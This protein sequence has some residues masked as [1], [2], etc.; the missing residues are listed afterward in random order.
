M[1]KTFETI[2]E[3][4]S[5]V[6]SLMVADYVDDIDLLTVALAISSM[7]DIAF[8]LNQ[9]KRS[10][11]RYIAAHKALDIGWNVALRDSLAK[12]GYFENGLRGLLELSEEN[13]NLGSR[14]MPT[15]SEAISIYKEIGLSKSFKRELEHYVTQKKETDGFAITRICDDGK[16]MVYLAEWLLAT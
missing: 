1:K 12:A 10:D 13:P 14:L 4:V 7:R 9:A 8:T 3:K 5:E 16:V 11:I 6:A 2:Q 15:F